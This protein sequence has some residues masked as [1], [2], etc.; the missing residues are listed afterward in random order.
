M[1]SGS[2]VTHSKSVLGLVDDATTGGA[3]NVVVLAAAQLVHG[4]LGVG[5]GGVGL[6]LA[7]NLVAGTGQGLLDLG[8]G[9]LGRLRLLTGVLVKVVERGR[10][11]WRTIFSP[12]LVWVSLRNASVILKSVDWFGLVWFGV[13]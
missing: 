12:S 11:R 3:V 6:E 5:L 7:G 13:V 8:A 10:R 2:V 1:G 4:R 9:G